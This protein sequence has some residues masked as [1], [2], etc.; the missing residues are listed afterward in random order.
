[1]RCWGR[2]SRGQLGNGNN[3]DATIPQTVH[4]ISTVIVITLG[5]SHTC[6][7]IDGGNVQ[8]WGS[9]FSGQLGNGTTTNSN[10]PVPVHGIS[11]A[12]AVSAG[13]NHTCAVL[14]G[15]NA[16]C[17]GWGGDVGTLGL[18]GINRVSTPQTVHNLSTAASIAAAAY[19]SCAV[20]DSGYVKCWGEGSSGKL[21]DSTNTNRF[22]PT[23]V[24]NITNAVSVA[25][26][27]EFSSCALLADR[28]VKCWGRL[29]RV[30]GGSGSSSVPVLAP[31][32]SP[33]SVLSSGYLG[34][35]VIRPDGRS[36]VCTDKTFLENV[37][38]AI[39]PTVVSNT[40]YVFRE[41]SLL[42][43][44]PV[45]GTVTSVNNPS[46]TAWLQYST[47]TN[48]LFGI[49]YSN[50]LPQDI[51]IHWNNNGQ[52]TQTTLTVT[53]QPYTTP[54]LL[55][56]KDDNLSD[57]LIP[58]TTPIGSTLSNPQPLIKDPDGNTIFGGQ[59]SLTQ[60]AGKFSINTDTGVLML[61]EALGLQNYRIEV[62][63]RFPNT[64]I[65][66]DLLA[67]YSTREFAFVI[68]GFE[69]NTIRDTNDET[70]TI[71]ENAPIGTILT[72]FSPE[73]RDD[74]DN[75]TTAEWSITSVNTPFEIDTATGIIILT[76]TVDYETKSTESVVITATYDGTTSLV[77]TITIEV[78]DLIERLSIAPR[79]IGGTVTFNDNVCGIDA[80]GIVQSDCSGTFTG[81]ST[82]T[83]TATAIAPYRFIGW[84]GACS[85]TSIAT[86]VTVNAD[87]ACVA[88]FVQG[89][90]S[91]TQIAI[92]L[93]DDGNGD[94]HY[95]CGLRN[96]GRIACS[97]HNTSFFGSLGNGTGD[98][99]PFTDSTFVHGIFTAIAI[100]LGGGHSCALLAD[101]TVRCW[102]WG[103]NGQLGNGT[104]N[105]ANYFPQ[106][107]HGISTAIA[108]SLGARHTCALLD[109]GDVQCW[110]WNSNGQLGINSTTNASTPQNVH[111]ISTAQAISLGARH[112]CALLDGGDV[113]CWGWNS[114][115]QLG[116]GTTTPRNIPTITSD[117]S[118]AV[119][120]SAA[121]AHTCALLA[122]RTVHCWGRNHRGQLGDGTTTPRNIPTIT[123]DI[124]TAV[125]V[126]I[127]AAH[128]CAI[129]D[130]GDVQ[131]WGAVSKISRI[132]IP[133]T[134]VPVA[135]PSLSP[136]T[137]ITSKFEEVCALRAN[138]SAIC[139]N[140]TFLETPPL[141]IPSIVFNTV[142]VFREHSFFFAPP[143]S[144]TITSVSD[145]P[146]TGWLQYSSSTS[147]F[148]GTADSSS[149][150]QDITIHWNNN[151][152]ST[153]TVFTIIPQPYTTPTSL[154]IEDG[155]LSDNFVSTTT[156]AES[157]L[158]N[159][160]LLVKDPD[161]KTISGGQWSLT[162][163]AGKFSIHPDTGV[164][165][166]TE[167]VDAQN[168]PIEVQVRFPTTIQSGLPTPQT[169]KE[170]G[171]VIEGFESGVIRDIDFMTNTI[172]ENASTDTALAGFSPE[173]RDSDGTIATGIQWSITSTNTP[174][175]I[176][177]DS[178]QIALT[179]TNVL[180]HDTRSTESLI[181]T[182]AYSGTTSPAYTITIEI[183]NVLEKLLI[184]DI[185]NR[186]NTIAK[187]SAVN[188]PIS[189]VSLQ[190]QDEAGR[191]VTTTIEWSIT[192]ADSL[193]QINT[194][195]GVITLTETLDERDSTQYNIIARVQSTENT[196][197]NDDFSLSIEVL[198]SL[199]L[200][201]KLFLEGP[202]Q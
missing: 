53:P 141:L 200:H 90:G 142:H 128:T 122:N 73:I 105:S 54:T 30:P 45:T 24:H 115:G 184:N 28:N 23:T 159:L 80:D 71:T 124:S 79:P 199:R 183:S 161:G 176:N 179:T 119:A 108:I 42:F 57:N 136:A 69:S 152:Q 62:Q 123:S 107:V 140:Q 129:L 81:G 177:P 60:N 135:I 61:T 172:A 17:W 181:I 87:I 155:N 95:Y 154:T 99:V 202:L 157:T 150:P 144:G 111:G 36:G 64:A 192:S 56:I 133:N 160:Q 48:L 76:G 1:M 117:I 72:G 63:V 6:V 145:L 13:T 49:A 114:N 162:Q 147:A 7:I 5:G 77:Y 21:G 171:F 146:S 149:T 39:T 41:H 113:Q 109:G 182:G 156:P 94:E 148:F 65:Q 91:Y 74:S 116:D 55:T 187:I 75:V 185:D 101:R 168:Y 137:S 169:T 194:T 153:Q 40:L 22:I 189:N 27:A 52:S 112:T 11:T 201:L 44:P 66:P 83:L 8:C 174:F 34:F 158:S 173:I 102:G 106:T 9:N 191:L 18:G 100:S 188:T 59:W 138:G 96:D 186:P 126:N 43:A 33:A 14:R 15:G 47:S 143:V 68:I 51:T 2:N 121:L 86:T 3:T 193:F 198:T 125:A 12:I 175:E 132:S 196:T 103:S 38:P 180:D 164:L 134:N 16:Q 78:I 25:L 98:F 195:T 19:H 35:C 26:S 37:E 131:C 151:G 197:I 127:S 139:R 67:P 89:S 163:N 4:G 167:T 93:D 92:G 50:S 120:I 130:G 82:V 88:N 165:M 190:A 104:T 31:G 29:N 58:I 170:F 178:G 70:D 166:L 110:G 10:T 46:P 97:G 85:D 20:L 32:L 118:T 84:S